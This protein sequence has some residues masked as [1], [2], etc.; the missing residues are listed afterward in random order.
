M[1]KSNNNDTNIFVIENI[2]IQKPSNIE[3]AEYLKSVGIKMFTDKNYR[4]ALMYFERGLKFISN[5]ASSTEVTNLSLSLQLNMSNCLVNLG[6]YKETLNILENCLK[7]NE[8]HPKIYYYRTLSYLNLN[9]VNK[10]E[11]DFNTLSKLIPSDDPVLE[12]LKSEI[13]NKK[14]KGN[15]KNILKMAY[16]DREKDE[17]EKEENTIDDDEYDEFN[18]DHPEC[19]CGI[20]H[21]IPEQRAPFIHQI[22]SERSKSIK[23]IE[24]A[25]KLLIKEER[26]LRQATPNMWLPENVFETGIGHFWGYHETRPYMR[27]KY[28]LVEALNESGIKAN[29]SEALEES[30]DCLR[31][32]KS[33]NMGVRCMIPSIFLKL[34]K[35]QECYDFIKWWATCDPDGTYDWGDM[36]LP[37]LNIKNA[38]LMED[39]NFYYLKK[40]ECNHLMALL[41]IKLR[42]YFTLQRIYRD[43]NSMYSFIFSLGND[44]SKSEL[45]KKKP[46]LSQISKFLIKRDYPLIKNGRISYKELSDQI[47]KINNQIEKIFNQV[48]KSNKHLLPNIIKPLNKGTEPDVYSVGSKEEAFIV[49]KN[50]SQLWQDK[51][52]M[53][54]TKNKL[55]KSSR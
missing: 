36:S 12:K 11:R 35:E 23:S 7:I 45:L 6:S 47:K 53:E 46:I 48:D 10:A 55:T 42:I 43:F 2:L 3:K 20:D 34:N 50:Y 39:V 41:L 18:D 1:E 38:N 4:D 8:N 31:L 5:E 51:E 33:D 44:N 32:C 37:Y 49:L 22:K 9:D 13:N 27:A 17:K 28:G 40:F 30:L 16:T 15:F 19:T 21:N 26:K 52:V 54:F 29:I 24:K 14:P 25:R